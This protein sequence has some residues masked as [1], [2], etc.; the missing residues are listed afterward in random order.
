MALAGV[1]TVLLFAIGQLDGVEV[2]AAS[3]EPEEVRKTPDAITC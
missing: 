2:T 1:S 3:K